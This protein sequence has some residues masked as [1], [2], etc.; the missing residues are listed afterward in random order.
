MNVER[1]TKLRDV[2]RDVP[3]SRFNMN[4]WGRYEMGLVTYSAYRAAEKFFDLTETEADFL[5][6][7]DAYVP[8]GADDEWDCESTTPAQV[9]EHIERLLAG[10]GPK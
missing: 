4:Y 6:H 2:L 5:F 3:A 1:L 10:E 9:V 7:P 8:L